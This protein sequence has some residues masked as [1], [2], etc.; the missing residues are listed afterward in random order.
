[1]SNAF[2]KWATFAAIFMG[3]ALWVF[4]MLKLAGVAVP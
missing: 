1:M 3:I 2:S 4:A